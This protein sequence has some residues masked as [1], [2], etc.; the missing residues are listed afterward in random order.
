MDIEKHLRKHKEDLENSEFFEMPQNLWEKISEELDETTPPMLAPQ[1]PKGLFLSYAILGRV[2][3]SVAVI[4]LGYWAFHFGFQK[5]GSQTPEQEISLK[6]INPELAEAETYYTSMISE[7]RKELEKLNPEDLAEFE[8]EFKMQ[9]SAYN[10][11]KKEFFAN[12]MQ[13]KVPEA[14]IEN[15]RL[16]MNILNKQVE[17]LEK[18]STKNDPNNS[19]NQTTQENGKV[20]L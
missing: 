12:P 7:K 4:F 10:M 19:R 13:Q 5:F 16:R 2:A 3:A 11:L 15:L 20:K 17:L 18:F 8:K 14:M 1:K 9:D 6:Q